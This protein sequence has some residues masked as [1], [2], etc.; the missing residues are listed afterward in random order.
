MMNYSNP[1]EPSS[2]DEYAQL[3]KYLKSGMWKMADLETRKLLYLAC[4][5]TVADQQNNLPVNMVPCDT[6]DTLD[7]LWVKYSKGRFGFS[8]QKP[9][10]QSC[11][12]KYYDKTEA[13]KQ[14]GNRVGWRS[15]G[16]FNQ[17][18]KKHLDLN[19]TADAPVGCFP[20]LGD[21]CGI[22]TIEAFVNQLEACSNVPVEEE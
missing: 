2:A 6:L 3:V 14:F 17:D 18:W 21:R 12:Q 5:L 19:F 9:I 16:L 22:L 13:W 4:G 10:W 11:V 15:K 1:P 20:H 8:V 7:K